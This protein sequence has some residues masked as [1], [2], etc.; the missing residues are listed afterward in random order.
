MICRVECALLVHDQQS[1]IQLNGVMVSGVP[2]VSD[3]EQQLESGSV[4]ES[5]DPGWAGFPFDS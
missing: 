2:M 5:L 4:R 1:V 3:E